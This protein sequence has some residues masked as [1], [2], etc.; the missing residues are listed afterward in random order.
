M[1][2]RTID[3]PFLAS[4]L[5]LTIGGFVIFSS[6]SLGLLARQGAVYE[7]V[8]T[9]QFLGL[10]IGAVL[11]LVMSKIPYTLW[12]KYSFYIFIGVLILNLLVFVPGVALHHG[13]ASRW[14]NLGFI[15][16]QPSEFLKIAFIIY[17]AAWLSGV[18]DQIRTFKMG[19]LPYILLAAIVGGIM[20]GQRDTD[21]LIVM[22][23]AGIAMLI[24]AG[25]RWKHII[26]LILIGL[27]A[28]ASVAATRPYARARIMTFLNPQADVRGAGYQ[29]NQSL[30]AIGSGGM[31]GRGFGQSVQKFNY[32]PEPIG[33]SIFAVAAEEFGFLGSII[34]I[35]GYLLF[36]FRSFQIS[37]RSPDS[38]SGLAVLGI[39]ILIIIESF[40]NIGAML[41]IVPLSGQPLLFV[42]HG[43]TALI[44]TLA[45]VGFIANVSRHRN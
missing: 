37:A 27:I 31:L 38:F 34:L 12:R 39:A 24:A 9:Y 16:F 1:R 33:D 41:G 11:F 26:L 14:I 21:A 32:L 40:M 13:G 17:F 8:T 7:S 28:I 3:K 5:F 22:L 15:T 18:K 45:A 2:L 19:I 25:A 36:V 10:M 42:S 44:I 35:L 6:A 43:G 30:I 20:L 29:V 23:G 4:I